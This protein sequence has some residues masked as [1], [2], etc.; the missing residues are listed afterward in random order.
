MDLTPM[1]IARLLGRFPHLTAV[2]EDAKEGFETVLPD[3]PHLPWTTSVNLLPTD[4][5]VSH[6]AEEEDRSSDNDEE[7]KEDAAT[8]SD[9]ALYLGSEIMR[10]VRAEIWD[11]LH[12]TCSAGIAHNKAMAKVRC[13][14]DYVSFGLLMRSALLVRA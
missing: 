4:T 9:W 10:D 2:P 1:V 6:A 5:E 8:W 14:M 12:Y 3:P 13:L 7:P 11:R